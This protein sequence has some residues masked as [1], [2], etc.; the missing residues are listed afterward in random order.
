MS[1]RPSP[2]LHRPSGVILDGDPPELRNT[3]E[4][5]PDEEWRELGTIDPNYRASADRLETREHL[6]ITGGA[7]A[8]AVRDN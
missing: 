5:V 2:T 1:R 6:E 7:L 3:V 4:D 8:V